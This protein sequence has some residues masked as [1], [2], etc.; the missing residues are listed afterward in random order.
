[1]I[2]QV[3]GLNEY[4]VVCMAISLVKSKMW[5]ESYFRSADEAA[6]RVIRVSTLVRSS[7]LA[8]D[9]PR[10]DT[11]SLDKTGV[12]LTLSRR[13]SHA[14]LNLVEAPSFQVAGEDNNFFSTLVRCQIL[15][16]YIAQADKI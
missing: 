13:H 7:A 14:E 15:S 10:F 5:P 12:L 9:S 16:G 2:I 11:N 4:Y 8:S 6:E 3:Q 1:M